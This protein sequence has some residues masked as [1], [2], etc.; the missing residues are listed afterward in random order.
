MAIRQL[1]YA[2]ELERNLKKKKPLSS[3]HKNAAEKAKVI[4]KRFPNLKKN[5]KQAKDVLPSKEI[6]KE[7]RR[8]GGSKTKEGRAYRRKWM[9]KHG[10]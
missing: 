1:Q 6:I 7:Y 9:K 8:L 2:Q 3:A 10:G 5:V 4:N